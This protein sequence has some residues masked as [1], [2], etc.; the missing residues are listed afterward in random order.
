[1][2]LVRIGLLTGYAFCSLTLTGLVGC[3]EDGTD[4]V[5]DP[6]PSTGQEGRDAHADTD[7]DDVDT[8]KDAGTSPRDVAKKDAASPRSDAGKPPL[9]D[10]GPGTVIAPDS[11]DL[12]PDAGKETDSSVPTSSEHVD[13]GMGDGKDV[14]TIGDSWMLLMAGSGIEVSLE[15]V[16]KRDYRNFGVPGTKLLDEVIPK[17]YETAKGQGAVKTVIMTGGGNDIIQ[18]KPTD[19]VDSAFG[20]VCKAQNDKVAARLVKLWDEMSSDGVQDVVLIGYTR[21]ASLLFSPLAKSAEYSS[22]TIPPLCAAVAPPLRCHVIDSDTVF[23]GTTREGIHPTDAGYDKIGAAV[24]KL[25][26]DEGMRR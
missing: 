22:A 7:D 1:M 26:Q 4:T 11:G 9:I 2:N 23:D 25:M 5:V 21:K 14:I 10:A 20:D 6:S 17:Q 12:K 15:K 3:A 19:C 13:Q 24:W 8:A 18:D 16:S